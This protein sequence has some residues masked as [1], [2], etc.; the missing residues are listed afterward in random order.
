[1]KSKGQKEIF[2]VRHGQSLSNE[3]PTLDFVDPCLTELGKKQASKVKLEDLD[4]IIC[5]SM[6]RALETLHYSQLRSDELLITDDC[7]EKVCGNSDKKLLEFR[8]S[9]TN[10]EFAIRMS[11]FASQLL[12]LPHK[13]I[14]VICHGCVI[15]ALTG[16]YLKNCGIIKCNILLI[17]AVANGGFIKIKCCNSNW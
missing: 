5:S 8:D 10:E 4:L 1:M 2:L 16:S 12:N 9:E 6:R 7:R 17:G 11:K 15:A 13:K 3:N 14:C